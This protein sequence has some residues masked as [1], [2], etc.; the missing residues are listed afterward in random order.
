MMDWINKVK[1][2]KGLEKVIAK[3]QRLAAILEC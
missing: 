1:I 3:I 2:R